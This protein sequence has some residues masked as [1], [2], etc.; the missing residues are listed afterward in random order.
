MDIVKRVYLG[1]PK[2]LKDHVLWVAR[3]FRT[4]P[5]SHKPGGSDVVVEYHDARVY[6][7]NRIKFPSQYISTI[8]NKGISE[9]HEDFSKYDK[10]KQLKI[11]KENIKRIFAR[12]YIKE[13]FDDVPFKEIWN[14]E[15]SYELP[16]KRLKEYD[17]DA[18]NEYIEHQINS[19]EY[20]N[21]QIN[22]SID[23][24]A[25]NEHL[26]NQIKSLEYQNHQIKK[27]ENAS[28]YNELNDYL[29]GL[30]K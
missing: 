28:D 21:H 15:K 10:E 3:N 19:W 6:G 7:Y 25:L 16:W 22:E 17:E 9:V 23:K 4:N 14:Y 2:S 8:W 12:K 30:C 18:P 1:L 11:I 20:Q 26:E 27:M 29:N 24:N 13:N 5:L